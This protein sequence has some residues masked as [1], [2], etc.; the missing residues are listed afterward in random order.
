MRYKAAK[1]PDHLSG[2]PSQRTTARSR[3][4]A[5]HRT[6]QPP[7]AQ[8]AQGNLSVDHGRYYTNI[9]GRRPGLKVTPRILRSVHRADNLAALA[10]IATQYMQ[11]TS[12]PH[13]TVAQHDLRGRRLDSQGL[14]SEPLP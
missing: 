6:I 5:K 3:A 7:V 4:T 12:L 1:H 9:R 10:K 11:A 14:H 13:E 8:A 2:P